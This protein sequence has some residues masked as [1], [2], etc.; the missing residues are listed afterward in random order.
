M[1]PLHRLPFIPWRLTQ[2][3]T[4]TTTN[5][6]PNPNPYFCLTIEAAIKVWDGFTGASKRKESIRRQNEDIELPQN[7]FKIEIKTNYSVPKSFQHSKTDI[8]S[9]IKIANDILVGN[10]V[11]SEALRQALMRKT[12]LDKLSEINNDASAT[13]K[14]IEGTAPY[15]AKNLYDKYKSP[16]PYLESGMH[17]ENSL[18][19]R[20]LLRIENYILPKNVKFSQHPYN[21]N[22]IQINKMHEDM[23]KPWKL[24]NYK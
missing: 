21:S 5:P 24:K 9:K 2:T 4:T 12:V 20:K 19:Q 10:K 15:V 3:L 7:D 6:N 13:R 22:L 23:H 18:S 1:G 17:N 14:N 11:L 8:N 16:L